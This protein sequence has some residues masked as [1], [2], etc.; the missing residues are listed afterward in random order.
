MCDIMIAAENAKF[1]LPEIKLGVIP[2]GG[3]TQRLIREIGKSKA[4]KMITTGEF[5]DAAEAHR[6]GL[7]SDVFP[8]DTMLDSAIDL[9]KKMAKFSMTSLSF[10]KKTINH[11]Y[12]SGLTQGIDYERMLFNSILGT[13]D[14]KIGLNA[15]V[16]KEKP[17]F[18]H[19]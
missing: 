7:V 16:N 12:E 5:I 19:E 4:M 15:F 2:G 13:K 18:T 1:G 8:V 14:A 10:S 9:A 6:I 17:N 3:G 11:A